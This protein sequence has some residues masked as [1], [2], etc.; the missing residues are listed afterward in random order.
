MPC[1]HPIAAFEEPSGRVR[2]GFDKGHGR[3]FRVPC[4]KCQGCKLERS[5][6]WAVRC[7]HESSLH[8]ENC[9]VTLTY[10]DAHFPPAGSLVLA[11]FQKFMRRLR[12]A[13]R[14]RK[15]RFYHAG[16]YG[17][18]FGRPHYH[19]ILFGFDFPD[20]VA[21]TLR[22]G[23]QVWTSALLSSLW[24]SGFSEIGSV[25]YESA[26]YV[27]GYVVGASGKGVIGVDCDGVARQ[28]KREYSTMS[29]R[30]G[31]GSGWLSRFGGEVYPAD[32]VVVNGQ[33]RKPPRYYDLA[34]AMELPEVFEEVRESRR[35]AR[36]TDLAAAEANCKSRLSLKRRELD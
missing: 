21:S 30:P 6:Q 17:T 34:V 29:R 10:D 14:P 35:R 20:K 13:I 2:I 7:M 12:K 5:R 31:I 36:R 32:G 23:F 33:L 27:A 16:E 9:F 26:A 11:D 8:D 19:A 15:V 4:G 22:R 3:P 28:L 1:F 18:Q 25:T 24:P